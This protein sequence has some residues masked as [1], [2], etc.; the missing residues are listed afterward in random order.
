MRKTAPKTISIPY[1]LLDAVEQYCS[2]THQKSFS[3]G[4]NFLMKFGPNPWHRARSDDMVKPGM[5]Q[6]KE[7]IIGKVSTTISVNK[8]VLKDVAAAAE[9]YA[10]KFNNVFVEMLAYGLQDRIMKLQADQKD[11]FRDYS[12]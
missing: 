5:Y 2:K 6:W 8:I 4:V 9:E 7:S 1:N 12:E 3:G 11:P 10:L